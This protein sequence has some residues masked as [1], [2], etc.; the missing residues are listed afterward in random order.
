VG[1]KASVVVAGVLV[2]LLGSLPAAWAQV[3]VTVTRE[4]ARPE[5]VEIQ[6]GQE[7]EWRNASGET[8]H[9]WFDPAT[10]LGFYI[11]P[12]GVRVKFGKPGTYRYDV[13][14]SGTRLHI[15]PGTVIVK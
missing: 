9:V 1:G 11:G 10:P 2:G 4:E 7:V 14:L 12:G 3:K 13:H 15:H 5:I 8:A 6:A